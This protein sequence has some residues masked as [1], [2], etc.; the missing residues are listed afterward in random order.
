VIDDIYFAFRTPELFSSKYF[1]HPDTGEPLQPDVMV[2]G[3][4]VAAGYP[5]SMVLGRQGFLLSYDKKYLLQVNKSVG[6]LSAWCGGIIA[7]NA[8]LEAMTGK[9]K[10]VVRMDPI[11]ELGKMITKF[12]N[13]SCNL[14]NKFETRNIPLRIR[15]FSNTFSINYLENSVYN[16][17]FPQYL[18]AEGVFLGNYSTG[19]WNM[20]ADAT[21]AD[22]ENLSDKFV[23]AAER[24]KEHG[25]FE[26]GSR[27]QAIIMTVQLTRFTFNYVK[28]FYDQIMED[29][30]IDIEVSHNHPVNKVCG[31]IM[32][33]C[34]SL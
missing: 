7:S 23:A 31:F 26:K 27:P 10:N 6:T 1:T 14:N 9:L 19:K 21:E 22:L 29:K 11:E 30:R 12:D 16:S 24:M 2:L 13:F 3:K 5:L 18:I 25:Y 28:I 32:S 8:F 17:R 15:N 34:P 33:I 4:G 20:N